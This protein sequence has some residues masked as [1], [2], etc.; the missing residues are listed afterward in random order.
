MIKTILFFKT[1]VPAVAGDGNETDNAKKIKNLRFNL[2]IR[3]QMRKTG[4]PDLFGVSNLT[5][6]KLSF[7]LFSGLRTNNFTNKETAL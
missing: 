5:I 7:L 4:T 3:G 2:V 1:N 6:Y